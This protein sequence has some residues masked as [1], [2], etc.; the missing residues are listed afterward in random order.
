[1]ATDRLLDRLGVPKDGRL[2]DLRYRGRGW[3][4]LMQAAWIDAEGTRHDS[5]AIPYAEGWGHILQSDRRRR[6]RVCA[7][8]TGA[9]ADISVGD[10]WHTPPEGRT[11]PGR[12]LIVARTA[13]GQAF[14]QAAIVA[15]ALVAEPRGRDVIAAA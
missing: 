6:C 15:G 9:F 14:I 4:G 11:D 1:M 13:R 8:H 7:D 12:S 5:D 2:V 3:P 10:P